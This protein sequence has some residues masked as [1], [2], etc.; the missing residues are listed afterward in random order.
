[1][2]RFAGGPPG[3]KNHWVMGRNPPPVAVH[4]LNAAEQRVLSSFISG[5]MPA[6]QVHT[7]LERARVAAPPALMPVAAVKPAVA[8]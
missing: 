3:K 7:Q 5:R 2:F 1:V 6:G 4:C 8:A